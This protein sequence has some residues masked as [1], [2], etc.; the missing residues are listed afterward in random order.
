[1]INTLY[2]TQSLHVLAIRFTGSSAVGTRLLI[3][4]RLSGAIILVFNVDQFAAFLKLEA[5]ENVGERGVETGSPQ[6]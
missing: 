4:G 1:V 5:I 6:L 3:F 2:K